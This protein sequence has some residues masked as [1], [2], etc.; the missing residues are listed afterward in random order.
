MRL[1]IAADHRG[2]ELKDKLVDYLH[3]KEYRVEDLGAYEYDSQDD[4]PDFAKKVATAVLQDVEN[5]RGIVICGSGVGADIVVNRHKKLRCGLGFNQEQIKHAREADNI[6]VLSLP[7]DY[8]DFDEAVILVD[9]FLETRAL[10]EEKYLRR[11]KKI[12]EL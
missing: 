3:E 12:D 11:I 9:T 5:S 2:F 4:Y 7:A 1:F 6:N 8:L 10:N